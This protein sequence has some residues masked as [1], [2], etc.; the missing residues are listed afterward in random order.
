ML[1]RSVFIRHNKDGSRSE[2]G[3]GGLIKRVGDWQDHMD[4]ADLIFCTDNIFY[5]YQ[6]ER[7]RDQGY[8]IFGP[9]V[10]TN[11]WEQER[12][13]GE[14]ILNKVGIETIPS[15][16]FDNYDKAM[17]FVKAN[18]NRKF[19]SKPIGDGAKDLSYVAKTGKE[20]YY[21]LDK[22]KKTNAYKGKFILQEFRKGIEFA[23][24]GWFGPGGFSKYITE[25]F[26]HKKLMSGEKGPATGE[27]GTVMR[28]VTNSKLFDQVLQPLEGMLLG[29]NYTGYIDV[30]CII[31]DNGNV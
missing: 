13:H 3:D 16:T 28:Y 2:V 25:S 10:D 12:D 20:M 15:Q 24:G 9:S 30:N 29:M 7:Y 4:W 27:M 8:P 23:V 6:L 26:E 11:R 19:V 14:K 21:M 22:W 1:F 17:E 31:E 5:I 18:P